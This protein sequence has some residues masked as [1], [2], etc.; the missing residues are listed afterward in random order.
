MTSNNVQETAIFTSEP[1]E[2]GAFH[3]EIA[4]FYYIV[5]GVLIEMMPPMAL[6][7]NGHNM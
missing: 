5:H 1:I 6:R 4:A 2:S 7:R 3:S